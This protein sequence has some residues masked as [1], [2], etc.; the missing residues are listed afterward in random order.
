MEAAVSVYGQCWLSF[1]GK[2][3]PLLVEPQKMILYLVIS[4]LTSCG[5]CIRPIL[6]IRRGFLHSCCHG[7]RQGFRVLE[8]HAC[9]SFIPRIVSSYILVAMG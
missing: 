4:L 8:S 5:N 6:G 1:S 2:P 9:V 3:K 7:D